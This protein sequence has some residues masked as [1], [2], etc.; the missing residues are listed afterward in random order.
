MVAELLYFVS[1]ALFGFTLL[2]VA[3]LPNDIWLVMGIFPFF[4][5]AIL[6]F[7]MWI[8]AWGNFSLGVSV[9]SLLVPIAAIVA[10]R[11]LSTRNLFIAVCTTVVL[12]LVVARFALMAADIG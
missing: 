11:R 2:G 6:G 9:G 12:G 4:I 10:L 1:I 7:V 5:A 3:R 8:Y